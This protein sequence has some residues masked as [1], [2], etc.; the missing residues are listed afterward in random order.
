[1]C[2]NLYLVSISK[3]RIYY[4]EAEQVLMLKIDDGYKLLGDLIPYDLHACAELTVNAYLEF[5]NLCFCIP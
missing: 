1:M 5:L 2:Q 4:S 3:E